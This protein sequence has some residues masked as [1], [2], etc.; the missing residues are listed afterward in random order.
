[1]SN[2]ELLKNKINKAFSGNTYQE[3]WGSLGIMTK[4]LADVKSAFDNPR[5]EL[6]ARS[7]KLTLFSFRKSGK[8]QTFLDVKY[9][10]FGVG[11]QI[12]DDEWCLL[13]DPELF[14]KLLGLVDKY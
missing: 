7:V 2:I 4:A 10:C 6:P 14:K 8:L 12:G 1:M 9:V 13:N 3:S 11:Q 5:D